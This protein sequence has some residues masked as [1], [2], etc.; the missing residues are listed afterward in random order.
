[1]PEH[2]VNEGMSMLMWWGSVTWVGFV[3]AGLVFVAVMFWRSL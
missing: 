3:C 1:M 2:Q